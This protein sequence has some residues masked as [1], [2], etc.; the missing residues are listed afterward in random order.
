[1]KNELESR[2]V[3]SVFEKIRQHGEVKSDAQFD[4]VHFLE[5][6]SAATDFDGYTLYLKDA[7]VSLNF[8]FHNQY[9]FD[10]DSHEQVEQFEKKLL[11]I[12]ANY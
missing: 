6:V 8:G 1:M 5:G 7:S 9:H 11:Y 2:L 10:S 3:L 4:K 12:D